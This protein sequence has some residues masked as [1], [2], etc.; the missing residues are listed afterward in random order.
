[1]RLNT[2]IIWGRLGADPD[3][4]NTS[5]G[6][7]VANMRI[8]VSNPGRDAGTTWVSITAFDKQAEF[9]QQYLQKGSAVLVRGRLKE[10]TWD[11]K[12]TGQKRSKLV[13][14]AEA[15]DFGASKAEQGD[16]PEQP[17]RQTKADRVMAPAYVPETP[18]TGTADEDDLP[19]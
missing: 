7:V 2:V 11:D 16:Q 6:K 1:M 8:G 10:E 5:G 9:A 4:R 13:I 19:F 12:A 3:I 15:L 17:R 18:K 14:M